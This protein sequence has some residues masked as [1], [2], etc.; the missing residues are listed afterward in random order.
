MRINGAWPETPFGGNRPQKS[1][2]ALTVLPDYPGST[3]LCP[4]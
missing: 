2:P 3:E 1:R 4:R